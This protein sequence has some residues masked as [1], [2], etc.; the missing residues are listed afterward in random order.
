MRSFMYAYGYRDLRHAKETFGYANIP[1]NPCGS[2]ERCTVK[3]TMG[4]DIR[5]RVQEIARIN[6][7]PDDFLSV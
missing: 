2:C 3:C 7:V 1:S 5:S 6:N 4:F